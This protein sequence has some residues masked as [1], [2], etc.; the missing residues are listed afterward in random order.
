M[1]PEQERLVTVLKDTITLLCKNSLS[2]EKQ[3]VVQGLICVTV[4]KED[5]LVVQVNDSLGEGNYEP[6]VACGHQKEKPPPPQKPSTSTPSE[7]RKR[8]RSPDT[9]RESYSSPAKAARSTPR[10]NTS[11]DSDTEAD[12]DEADTEGGGGFE[13]LPVK[14]EE[15]IE[16]KDIV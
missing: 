16:S 2:Y 10:S 1:K 8:A 6:C 4:D 14:K 12:R 5:V 15:M 9:N 3:V 13:L 7:N 11:A